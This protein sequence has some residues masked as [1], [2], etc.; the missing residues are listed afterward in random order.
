MSV[1]IQRYFR[2]IGLPEEEATRLHL[3]YREQ[4]SMALR[5]LLL[6]HEIDPL[7]YDK[8]CDAALPLEDLLA[9]DPHVRALLSSLDRRKVKLYALTNAYRNV[10]SSCRPR[11]R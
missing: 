6:H 5:G 2:T 8:N 3:R 4:Y 7:D 10:S 1:L 9:P 11:R